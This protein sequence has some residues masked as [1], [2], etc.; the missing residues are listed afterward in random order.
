M[1]RLLADENFPLPVVEE[2]RRLGH[3]NSNLEIPGIPVVDRIYGIDRMRH[4]WSMPGSKHRGRRAGYKA[5]S[6]RARLIALNRKEK[7]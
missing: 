1:S 6:N 5:I 2:L 7:P 3:S 4:F